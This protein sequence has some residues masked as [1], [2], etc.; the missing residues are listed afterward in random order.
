MKGNILSMIWGFNAGLAFSNGMTTSFEFYN[1]GIII[2]SIVVV[3]LE[4]MTKK[5][6]I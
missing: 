5:N 6:S 2:I 3:V 4:C 1:L